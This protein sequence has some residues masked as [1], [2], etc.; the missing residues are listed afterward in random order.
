MNW[1]LEKFITDLTKTV[2]MTDEVS[3]EGTVLYTNQKDAVK[4]FYETLGLSFVQ[5]QHGHGPE[6]YAAQLKHNSVLEIYPAVW[7]GARLCDSA[8][9]S[10]KIMLRVSGLDAVV[11]SLESAGFSVKKGKKYATVYDPDGRAVMLSEKRK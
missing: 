7:G 9:C 4:M 5:E 2:R 3:F 11:A 1:M 6:H 10:T 8:D